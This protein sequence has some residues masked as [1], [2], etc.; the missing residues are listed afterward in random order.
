MD[1][2]P[3]VLRGQSG[4]ASLRT[5]L[6]ANGGSLEALASSDGKTRTFVI[7][8]LRGGVCPVIAG[9]AWDGRDTAAPGPGA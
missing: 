4:A 3:P 5:G 8:T 2:G 1:G 6:S 9:E 7:T